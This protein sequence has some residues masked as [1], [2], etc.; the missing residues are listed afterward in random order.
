MQPHFKR[1]Q[2][3]L[4]LIYGANQINKKKYLT[5]FSE[6]RSETILRDKSLVFIIFAKSAIRYFYQNST[7]RRWF[8][9]VKTKPTQRRLEI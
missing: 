1:F 5:C 9:K 2:L 3:I 4:V 8:L 7:P 6:Y